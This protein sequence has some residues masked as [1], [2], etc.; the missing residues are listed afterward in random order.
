MIKTES[1]L[2]HLLDE[3]C[4]VDGDVVAAN[5]LMPNF[6]ALA[7][8]WLHQDSIPNS[9]IMDEFTIWCDLS[10]HKTYAILK[11]VGGFF[12]S[13][14]VFAGGLQ[15]DSN[16]AESSQKVCIAGYCWEPDGNTLTLSNTSV[17]ADE[18]NE[19]WCDCD[20]W[21]FGPCF[22]MGVNP[23]GTERHRRQPSF[24]SDEDVEKSLFD[25]GF[26]RPDRDVAMLESV[27][28]RSDE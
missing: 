4:D 12:R 7:Y 24:I 22:F 27:F 9:H 20:D 13:G 1:D 6:D 8:E 2:Q 14:V 23:D 19:A 16:F 25:L 21:L 28:A 11:T 5:H 10:S 15:L 3:C 18:L 26:R 17:I